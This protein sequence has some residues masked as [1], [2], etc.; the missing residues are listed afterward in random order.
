MGIERYSDIIYLPHPEPRKHKRMTMEQRAAQFAP[1]AALSGHGD[2]VRETERLTDSKVLLSEE[3]VFLLNEKL[4]YL[5]DNI[6]K[7]EEVS[8]TYFV[9]DDKKDGGKYVACSGV[10]KRIDEF[11]GKIIMKDLTE[12]PICDIID[13]ILEG[14]GNGKEDF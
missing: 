3:I 11:E 7:H 10:V 13:M 4:R 12:I 6:G 1:F 2:A 8:I 5:K 9:P 14:S